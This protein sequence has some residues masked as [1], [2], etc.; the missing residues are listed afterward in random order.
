MLVGRGNTAKHEVMRYLVGMVQGLHLEGEQPADSVSDRILT[1]ANVVTAV[2]LAMIPI[3]FYLLVRGDRNVSAFV[4]FA[5]AASTDWI[6]GQIAR[7]TNTVTRL[8]KELD[9]LVDRFLIAAGVVGLVMVDRLPL[10]LASVLIVRDAL[11]L[12]G[13]ARLK[14][15]GI[16]PIPV[17]Y[18]GK[19]ATALLMA[20]FS[21]LILD[22]PQVAGIGIFDSPHLPGMGSSPVS[23]WVWFVY[24]GAI[25][26]VVTGVIYTKLG[27][28][29][30]AQHSV[31]GG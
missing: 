18:G 27:R 9:P 6:D 20:G 3:A 25:I 14:L 30:L 28:E 21:G 13:S 8:G 22:W 23:L 10:W 19:V 16:E 17:M 26:S 4:V 11:L 24:G 2:R 5:L 7:R 31:S 1:V 15:L 12:S 29:R